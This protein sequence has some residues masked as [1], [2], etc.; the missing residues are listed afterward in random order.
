[1]ALLDTFGLSSGLLE[2]RLN[3]GGPPSCLSGIDI[4]VTSGKS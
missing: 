2:R 1:M 4:A 3:N